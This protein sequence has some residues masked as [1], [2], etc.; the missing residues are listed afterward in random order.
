MRVAHRVVKR[1]VRVNGLALFLSV[2]LAGLS[3]QAVAGTV[4]GATPGS[5]GVD[6]FGAATYSIPIQIPP[7]IAGMQP[8][9]SLEYNSHSGN[10][11]LGAG[12]SL[13]GLSTIYRCPKTIAT[14]ATR[15]GAMAFT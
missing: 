5:F 1:F 14:D 3:P 13:A 8:G 7:G 6:Q 10:G 15:G 9:L 4:A 12:W 2:S 11:L